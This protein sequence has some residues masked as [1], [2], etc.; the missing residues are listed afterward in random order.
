MGVQGSTMRKSKEDL[1][2]NM[3]DMIHEEVWNEAEEHF[4]SKLST[5]EQEI[6][7]LKAQIAILQGKTTLIESSQDYNYNAS[8]FPKPNGNLIIDAVIELSNS[9]REKGK[10]IINTKTDWYMVWKVLHYFKVYSG[11]QYDFIPIVN[12]CVLPYITDTKR[13]E[14]LSV[15]K[16]NFKNIPK[17]NYMKKIPVTKWRRELETQREA[18]IEKPVQHGTLILDRGINIMVKLQQLL[19]KKGVELYNYEK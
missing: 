12:D 15:V 3:Y 8:C 5:K 1:F 4:K 16:L 11:S 2:S 19:M 14:S 10:F 18:Y 7:R 9:Y 13:R 17:N 6:E